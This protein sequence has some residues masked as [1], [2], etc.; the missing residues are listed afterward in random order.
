MFDYSFADRDMLMRYHWGLAVGHVYSHRDSQPAGQHEPHSNTAEHVDVSHN[1]SGNDGESV[2][3]LPESSRTIRPEQDSS[4]ENSE[5]GLEDLEDDLRGPESESDD[6][7]DHE[8]HD[9]DDLE[10]M[11]VY[12]MDESGDEA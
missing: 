9:A 1:V 8:D 10:T 2:D 3:L 5:L 6:A 7:E 11:G 12:G 4:D